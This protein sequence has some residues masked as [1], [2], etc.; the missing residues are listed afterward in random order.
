MKR[1]TKRQTFPDL[2]EYL[3][4]DHPTQQTDAVEAVELE[5]AGVLVSAAEVAVVPN[6][7]DLIEM[8]TLAVKKQQMALLKNPEQLPWPRILEANLHMYR[9][10]VVAAQGSSEAVSSDVEVA[11][12]DIQSTST[13]KKAV[14]ERKEWK[15]LETM[16]IGEDVAE[17]AV[18]AVEVSEEME[19]SE[20]IVGED[21][22]EEEDSEEDAEVSV[23]DEEVSEE[24]IGA[25]VC[26]V[27][28]AVE[29]VGVAGEYRLMV[30]V[31]PKNKRKSIQ[32]QKQIKESRSTLKRTFN[33]CVK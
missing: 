8:P 17:V 13:K 14:N 19:V 20:E 5:A 22:A 27:G 6:Q 18:E 11:E 33:A 4:K 15:G 24:V 1:V 23:E 25:A 21:P 29:V 12:P 10:V 32:Q 31:T 3:S 28:V 7:R 26:V 30:K 2:K 9:E 16:K